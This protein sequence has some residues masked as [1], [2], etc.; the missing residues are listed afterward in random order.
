M[1]LADVVPRIGFMTLLGRGSR[2][3]KE[4]LLVPWRMAP[5]I[6]GMRTSYWMVE[7]MLSIS[8]QGRP[9]ANDD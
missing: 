1:V 4:S 6:C 5:W 7:S 8:N 9:A 3:V 2:A